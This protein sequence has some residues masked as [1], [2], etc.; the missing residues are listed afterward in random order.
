[1]TQPVTFYKIGQA[2]GT[3]FPPTTVRTDI[4]AVRGMATAWDPSYNMVYT[5]TRDGEQNAKESAASRR[6]GDKNSLLQQYITN[7]Q[8]KKQILSNQ[9]DAENSQQDQAQSGVNQAASVLRA[10]IGQ[11][12]T[13]I[14]SIFQAAS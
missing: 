11:L 4:T 1:M 5:P 7:A 3:L 8:T 9:Q 12:S 14:T 13:I 6:R 10:M 2:L